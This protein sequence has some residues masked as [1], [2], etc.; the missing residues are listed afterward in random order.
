MSIESAILKS[1]HHKYFK[2]VSELYNEVVMMTGSTMSQG[3]FERYLR[4][5]CNKFSSIT[6]KQ[7]PN[8]KGVLY[9]TY[10]REKG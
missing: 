7:V 3:T 6:I 2:E 1:L 5:V 8:Q 9:N 10:G 4:K